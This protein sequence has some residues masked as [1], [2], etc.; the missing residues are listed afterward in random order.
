MHRRVLTALH[1]LEG[2]LYLSLP[3][4]LGVIVDEE[5]KAR[6]RS[7]TAMQW[8][9]LCHVPSGICSGAEASGAPGSS[10]ISARTNNLQ[11]PVEVAFA[12]TQDPHRRSLMQTGSVNTA[13]PPSFSHPG[14][15]F[16]FNV[17]ARTAWPGW[18]RERPQCLDYVHNQVGAERGRAVSLRTVAGS[19]QGD[20]GACYMF[21]ALDSLSDRHCIDATNAERSGQNPPTKAGPQHFP[22]MVTL[23]SGFT[24]WQS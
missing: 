8:S 3:G 16:L 13:F 24:T 14:L 15:C 18:L 6:V 7:Q 17:V 5:R 21:A 23:I 2:E 1:S 4:G 22:C 12:L 20:C 9:I 11:L 10:G 19:R